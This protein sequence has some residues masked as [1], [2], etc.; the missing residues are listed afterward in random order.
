M[1][2]QLDKSRLQ[3]VIGLMLP[4]NKADLLGYIN[5]VQKYSPEK[6]NVNY[7]LVA[8]CSLTTPAGKSCIDLDFVTVS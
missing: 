2:D 4:R 3:L 5:Y 7:V 1:N 8:A 6:M